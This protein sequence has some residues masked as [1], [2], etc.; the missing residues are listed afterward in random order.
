[1]S[2]LVPVLAAT[3]LSILLAACWDGDDDDGGRV[4]AVQSLQAAAGGSVSDADTGIRVQ[5]PPGA[6]DRDTTVTL[7]RARGG[8]PDGSALQSNGSAYEVDLGGATLSVP[9][10]VEIAAAQAPTHP[11]LGEIATLGDD[12][13]ARLP[14]NFY[15]AG[16]GRVVGLAS[17]G[18]RFVP[19]LRRLQAM[20]G[21]SVE[22]G[23]QVFM[24]ET[25][26]NEAFFG[27]VLGLHTLLNGLS[28]VQAVQAGVQV[29]LAK[30]PAPIVAALT[31]DD[32]AAKDAALQDPAITRALVKAGAVVGVKGVY[33]DPSSDT[34]TAAG[35]TCALC[36]VNVAPTT[37]QLSAGQ[38]PLPIG[39]LQI[40]GRPN[41]AMDAGAILSLTPFVQSQPPVVAQ[42]LQGW[43]PG[44][45][46]IRALPDNPLEDGVDNPTSTPPLWNFVDLEAQVY[47]Y[48]WDGLFLSRATPN[49]ALA[50]Q[51]EA[52]YDLVMH[53]NGAFGTAG[54]SVPP[55]LAV[56]PPP[57][58]LD[59]LGAAESAAPGNDIP[60]DRLRDVQDFQRSITSPAPGA[61]DEA[62]AEQGFALFNG[63]ANCA[64]CHRTA[65]FTGPVISDRITLSPPTG[66]LAGGI[67]T[68]GLRGV[69][70]T[71]PFFH[72]G[73][74]ATLRDVMNV[75]SGRIVPTLTDAEKDALV[76]YLK[77]L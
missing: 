69:S 17:A 8:T 2:R 33:A 50:S 7:R 22:R 24:D 47:P 13:W 21:A 62:L 3:S 18:G 58:L 77:S 39:P 40:D 32:L 1:M 53:A 10:T 29:D 57:A 35:I 34:M 65:E 27:N 55:Q 59:A 6:L 70:Q 19:V 67:K 26:G 14:A 4:L 52:V 20:S 12:G 68:P 44:R 15:R 9:M 64:G 76:E 73:S 36:H 75:Y 5:V 43:G 56:T 41:L 48:D 72:D 11:E 60:A 23:R 42:T 54:G 63:K 37:F 49:D 51:A 16:D 74:A 31:G 66:G 28:P 45:F 71:A 30:V 61:Y 25:F 46:D 38:V